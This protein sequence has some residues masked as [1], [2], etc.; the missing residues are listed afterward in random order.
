MHSVRYWPKTVQCSFTPL[1]KSV[2]KGLIWVGRSLLAAAFAMTAVSAAPRTGFSSNTNNLLR[3]GAVN[4]ALVAGV[5]T[6]YARTRAPQEESP[7][8]TQTV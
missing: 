4:A 3:L 8:P 7:S 1:S 6:V 5:V 2:H